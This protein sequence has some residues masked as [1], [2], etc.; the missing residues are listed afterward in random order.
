MLG[1]MDDQR[2]GKL[3]PEQLAAIA[4]TVFLDVPKYERDKAYTEIGRLMGL[5]RFGIEPIFF[6]SYYRFAW[7]S[8][9][10]ADEP[11]RNFTEFRQMMQNLLGDAIVPHT[12][13]L[14]AYIVEEHL[15]E[16]DREEIWR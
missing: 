11:I 2:K 6:P 8:M 3:S 15:R 5:S 14:W 13:L 16:E 10:L 7:N 1:D 9:L 4:R 12:G